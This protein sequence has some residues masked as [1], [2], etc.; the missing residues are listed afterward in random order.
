MSYDPITAALDFGGKLLDKFIADPK[1]KD[2]AKLKLLEMTQNGDLAVLAAET[3]LLE[4]QLDINKEEAKS[5]SLFV[6]GWRPAIG[7]CC[8]LALLYAA[9]LEPMLRFGAV[10]WF[11]Y[12]GAFP[13]IDT[14]LTMQILLGML[15]LAGMR[16]YEKKAGVAAK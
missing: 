13:V 6:S 7:W 8:G 2:E 10:V 12:T 1:Q 16:S 5:A 4:G 3:K 9:I 14:N 15:G 11:D